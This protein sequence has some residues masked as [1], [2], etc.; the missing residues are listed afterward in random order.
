M[1]PITSWA[2]AG[3]SSSPISWSA[4]YVI[5]LTQQEY[6]LSFHDLPDERIL[7]FPSFPILL[8]VK[9]EVVDVALQFLLQA[10]HRVVQF[11]DVHLADHHQVDVAVLF[12]RTLR[13]GAVD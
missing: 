11:R 7:C 9:G 6:L 3:R 4:S 8:L 1:S 13:E 10:H 12:L 5:F 2:S